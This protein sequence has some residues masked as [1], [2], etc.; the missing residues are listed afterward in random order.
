MGGP[1]SRPRNEPFERPSSSSLFPSFSASVDR[2]PSSSSSDLPFLLWRSPRG[3]QGRKG[4][5]RGYRLVPEGARE[6]RFRGDTLA[7]KAGC[8]AKTI[9]GGGLAR[10][11]CAITNCTEGNLSFPCGV[12][13]LRSSSPRRK[14]GA[15]TGHCPLQFPRPFVY[16]QRALS[17]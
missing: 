15:L 5:L 11:L 12:A 17:R 8:C 3:R 14:G 9:I 10:V 7:M 6:D 2:S 1:F 4:S 13:F 16:I